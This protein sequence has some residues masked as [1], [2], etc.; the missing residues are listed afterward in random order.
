MK[1]PIKT[2]KIGILN[3]TFLLIGAM[4]GSAIF[5]LSGI[6]IYE[7]GPS[8]LLSWFLAAV[9]MLVYGL[10][11]AELAGYFPKSGGIYVFP[12]RAIPGKKGK[13]LA[14]IT[15][16][17]YLVG[18][19]AAISFSA[20]YVGIYLE[21]S[22]SWA[23]GLSVP[24]AICSIILCLL[25]NIIKLKDTGKLNIIMV[26]V[27]I[28]ITII[29]VFVAIDNKD[30][31]LPSFIPFFTQG[32]SGA[33]GFVSMI[34]TAIVAYSSVV[35]V[36]FMADEVK[37]PKKTISKSCIIA[38]SITALLYLSI[39]FSCV[40]YVSQGYIEANPQMKMIPL[41][42]VCSQISNS[43]WLQCLVSIAAVLSLLTTILVLIAMNARAIQAASKDGFLPR[44]FSNNS[45][46][47]QPVTAII[48]TC[49]IPA[50]VSIFPYFV[51]EVVNLGI[52]YN[53]LTIIIVLVSVIFARKQLSS[54]QNFTFFK[55]LFVIF[56]IAIL[57]L[58]NITNLFTSN[59]FLIGLYTVIIFAIGLL[60]YWIATK[61]KN[62]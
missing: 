39:I 37:N 38:I 30:N 14:W 59:L 33:F 47:N 23:Q 62:K 9:I 61:F 43:Y 45:K 27:L 42:A 24:I 4:F 5:S 8:S 6:T 26:C 32:H 50:I 17:G 28:L 3:S 57:V 20:I 10:Y 41:F 18:N 29:F 13:F 12:S 55:T 31:I 51:N 53:A 52:F 25:L 7:A 15:C 40:L 48:L 1:N 11:T 35:A 36:A 60:I 54:S 46:N 19:F 34:P 44:I 16:W 58:C 2:R 21:A 22:F 49:I 56:F